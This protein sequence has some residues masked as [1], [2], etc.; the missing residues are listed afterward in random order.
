MRFAHFVLPVTICGIILQ[1]CSAR[2]NSD[3]RVPRPLNSV[4]SLSN[5]ADPTPP[6]EEDAWF[7][8]VK[9]S[10]DLDATAYCQSLGLQP[11]T[12]EAVI[13]GARFYTVQTHER[14]GAVQNFEHH[15]IGTGEQC[16]WPGQVINGMLTRRLTVRATFYDENR[17]TSVSWEG[18]GDCR[19]I[20][21]GMPTGAATLTCFLDTHAPGYVGGTNV[22]NTVPAGSLSLGY[23]ATSLS[24]LRLWRQR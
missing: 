20:R 4:E 23:N 8:R 21:V 7:F 11:G 3:G 19:T 16:I 24:S 18:T 15:E 14:T 5:R 9:P 17:R 10:P 12:P 6:L 1:A 2:E 13:Q 22:S